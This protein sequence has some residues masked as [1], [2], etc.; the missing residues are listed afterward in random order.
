[1]TH[2]FTIYT[3]GSCP[4][5][6]EGPGGWASVCL[7]HFFEEDRH[8][9]EYSVVGGDPSTTNNRMEM[10]AVIE[11]LAAL[12]AG[13]FITVVSDSE[14]V[15]KG[16]TEWRPKWHAAGWPARIKNKD[17]WLQMQGA[18]D[19]HMSVIFKHVRGHQGEH[20]NEM[21]DELAGYQSAKFS[22]TA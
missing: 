4:K 9:P 1:V 2:T 3:D 22:E 6:P 11:G 13:S 12:P 16:F 14:Y 20:Y 21:A 18:V 8:E 7:Q 10:T 19:R 5:N 15:V 17:L